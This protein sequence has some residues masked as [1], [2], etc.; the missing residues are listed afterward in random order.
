M[1]YGRNFLFLDKII[2]IDEKKIISEYLLPEK[3]VFYDGHFKTNTVVPSI[4]QIEIMG[5]TG[6]VAHSIYLLKDI[7]EFDSYFPLVTAI[8]AEFFSICKPG[9]QLQVENEIIYNRY[10]TIKAKI[11]LT[12]SKTQTLVSQMTGIC[13]LYKNE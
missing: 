4:L 1:P 11:K 12:N 7:K 13:K 3:S 6:L 2:Y 9:M 10:N 5:Q 8:D